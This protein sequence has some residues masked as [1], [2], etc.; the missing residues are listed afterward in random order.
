MLSPVVRAFLLLMVVAAPALAQEPQAR[1]ARLVVHFDE[2]VLPGD[3][4]MGMLGGSLLYEAR[5][6]LL[7][8]PSSYGALTGER[9]GFITL[10][11]A[12]EAEASL[13]ERLG[14]RGGAF[15]GAGGGRGGVHLSGGGLMLRGYLGLAAA[16]PGIRVTGGVSHVAFPNRGSIRGAQGYLGVEYPFRALVLDDWIAGGMRGTGPASRSEFATVYRRYWIPDGVVRDDGVSAQ[17][18]RMGLL[19]VE[20][21]R[22]VSERVFVKIESEGHM[23][24]GSEGYMQIF[25]GVG[26]RV[27]LAP[28]TEVRLSG[29]VGVAGGGGVATG[30]GFLVDGS[31]LVQQAL[32]GGLFVAAGPSWIRAPDGDFRARGLTAMA[33]YDFETPRLG[34]DGR[35]VGDLLDFEGRHLRVRAVHQSYLQASDD[36]RSHHAH[37][38][39]HLLGVKLD[40]RIAPAFFLTGQGIAAH[41]GQA[42]AYM[43]G[44]VGVGTRL[45]LAGPV[46]LELETLVGAAGGGGLRFG[47]GLAGQVNG[48]VVVALRGALELSAG[49]GR[50]EALRG[51]FAAHVVEASVGYR[52]TVFGRGASGG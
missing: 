7:L 45:P 20:W 21:R 48:A 51:D 34:P 31:A 44:L 4:R 22:R 18:D 38:D 33:G 43:A 1:D 17:P 50:A 11:V 42:G 35:A 30:G 16:L 25:G 13:T 32:P 27:P 40:Y 52:L 29:A 49:Y 47:G 41:E 26:Y 28:S 12:G 5:P 39:V 10:G 2:Y 9:G 23:S 6:W 19:G 3:E 14:V 15:V 24:G 46:L 36:W 8:G 37:L